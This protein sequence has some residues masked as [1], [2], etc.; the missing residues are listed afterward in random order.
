M[1]R[2]APHLPADAARLGA[3]SA[4]SSA[5]G[6]RARLAAYPFS[7]GVASGSPLPDGRAVDAHPADPLNAA[8]TAPVALSV[9]WEVAEDER[10]RRIIA[11]GTASAAPALAHSVHVDVTGLASRPLVL[12]PLHAG[13]RRQPG[14]PHAHRAGAG[15]CRTLLKLAVASCQHWEFGSYAAHRHI[16]RPRPTWWPSWATTSTSGGLTS[17]STRTSAVRTN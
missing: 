3:L 7:L 15:A 10:F 4:L 12:V 1:D 13:R 17:R 9:R 5:S 8:A 6:M 2:A 14:R 11:K 16:A